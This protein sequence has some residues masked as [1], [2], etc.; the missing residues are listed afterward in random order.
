MAEVTSKN[1]TGGKKETL[2]F[3]A[4]VKQLL[5][6]MINS[7][8]SNKE[9]F[10]RELVSNA[11]DACDKLRFEAI[12][13][14][15]LY[16]GD[17]DLKVRISYDANQRTITIAD[18]GIGMNRQEVIDHIGTIAKSG[19]KEFFSKLT[20][21]QKQ[22][23]QIIG[24]FGVGFYSAFIVAD[25]V[26]LTTRRAGEAA[27]QA[28][29]WES[30]GAG[31]YSLESVSKESRGTEIVLHLKDGEDEFLDDYRLERVVKR[32]S[33][34]ISL[35]IV[36]EKTIEE[37]EGKTTKK[38]ETIN[39]GTAL[40]Q[41]AKSQIKQEEYDEFYK[42][43][44]HDFGKPLAHLHSKMEGTL[45]YT[46]LFYIPETAPFD[47]FTTEKMSGV[48]LYVKRVFIMDD[49]EKLLPRYLRFVRGVI[50]SS[51]LSL[52]VS[53]EILQDDQIIQSIRTTAVKKILDLLED[54]AQNDKEKYK[55]FWRQFGKV[56][57]E[58]LV[59]DFVNRD[60]LAKL[61]RFSSTFDDKEEQDV[62]LDDYVFRMK[63][64]QDKIY[65]IV[66]DG[67]VAAKNSPQLEVFRKKGI[68]V[69]LL[70]DRVDHWVAS[71]LSEY[72]E[73]KLQSITRGEIDLD[74]DESSEE[75]KKEEDKDNSEHKALLGRLQKILIDD[76]KEVRVS[77][78]LTSSPS[79][80]VAGENDLDP[81]LQ[82][83][84]EQMGQTVPSDKPILEIN[85]N[86]K[87]IKRAL[88][89][90]NEIAFQQLAQVLYDQAVLLDGGQLKD[91]VTFVKNVNALLG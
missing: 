43:V 51:D 22:D 82:R 77:K 56:L 53:R 88:G 3:Q 52:N 33:D 44:S 23:A 39:T 11:S 57:K 76:V 74:K 64:D 66:A 31:E 4:E 17:N 2:G 26:T 68:E 47:L 75:N 19:S 20:G 61:C 29:R 8:Y 91:P 86:H 35:P 60:R 65:Y 6:L 40:W 37:E 7:L 89:E 63:K 36:L 28:V 58:G 9:I 50:D 59:E 12:S 1:K 79:C 49:S 78:R 18:N 67:F 72:K 48:K 54:M 83:M 85:A 80:L 21:D 87:L 84:F 27:D 38:D 71:Q 10:L 15:A 62:S 42:T 25:K 45:E 90:E 46:L 32:F 13:N 41:R 69:L 16:E 34:H 73:K 30:E 14:D 70:S 55:V 5:N 81:K 24:Q